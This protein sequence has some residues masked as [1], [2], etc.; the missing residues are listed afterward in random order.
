MRTSFL[1]RTS[2]IILTVGIKNT[3]KTAFIGFHYPRVLTKKKFWASHPWC[4]YSLAFNSST[5]VVH[6]AK[7][8]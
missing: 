4:K 6:K 3:L 7:L 2:A 5:Y 1:C 8:V